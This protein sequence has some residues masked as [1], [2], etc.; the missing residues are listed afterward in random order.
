MSTEEQSAFAC[1]YC[2]ESDDRLGL[3]G[4]L[5]EAHLD[6]FQTAIPDSNDAIHFGLPCPE[7][8]EESFSKTIQRPRADASR[9]RDTYRDELAMIA[10]DQLL[11]HLEEAHGY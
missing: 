4:H 9:V 7:C 2:E 1:P 11:Y 6:R 5:V 8:A 3:H 10:F